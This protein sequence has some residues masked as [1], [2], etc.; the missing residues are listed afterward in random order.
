MRAYRTCQY[1]RVVPAYGA[2]S[3]RKSRVAAWTRGMLRMELEWGGV[4]YSIGL[5]LV[6]TTSNSQWLNN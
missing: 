5:T 3:V 4:G 1:A 2:M 6:L